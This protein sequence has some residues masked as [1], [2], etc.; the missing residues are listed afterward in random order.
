MKRRWA[1]AG[2]T[3]I[4]MIMAMTLMGFM[5][6]AV[7]MG[8]VNVIDG[9][10][11][12]RAASTVAAKGQLALLRLSREFRV[13]SSVT[14]ASA[15]SITFVAFHG[16]N[17]DGSLN[18][19]TYTVTQTGDLVTL[20]DGGGNNDTLVDKVAALSFAYFDTYTGAAET[21]WAATRKV[22]E[23]TL[24]LEGPG[25]D[26]FAFTTRVVPRNI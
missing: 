4:E 8:I 1:Q 21:T 6:A 20:N 9:Y 22:V 5:A 17:A 13:I 18:N 2:F 16:Y 19:K 7:G 26:L 24:T 14:S 11:S 23:V 10:M 3:L 12:S 15:T 25:N